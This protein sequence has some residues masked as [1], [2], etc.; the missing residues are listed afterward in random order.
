MA[1]R[2]S[3]EFVG[4]QFHPEADPIGMAAHFS[5]DIIKQKIIINFGEAKYNRMM[6]RMD[7]PDKIIKT[8]AQIL[9]TFISTAIKQNTQ[10]LIS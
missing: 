10:Q 8:Y 7:D 4:T 2:F 5:E 3:E 9:P 1:V 6:D